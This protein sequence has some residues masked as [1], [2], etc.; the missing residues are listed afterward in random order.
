MADENRN[1]N[2]GEKTKHKTN[3]KDAWFVQKH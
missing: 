2:W 1:K 3:P